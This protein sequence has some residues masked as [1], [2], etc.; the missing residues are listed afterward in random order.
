MRASDDERLARATLMRLAEPGDP[1]L[2]AYV[3]RVGPT[4]AVEAIED[5]SAALKS[6]AAYRARLAP[7]E[8]FVPAGEAAASDLRRSRSAGV[9]LVVPGDLEWP[10][11][12]GDLALPKVDGHPA[13]A[14][15]LGLWVRGPDDLRMAVLRSVAVVG[16][17]AATAY[18]TRVASD[19]GAGLAE[20]GYCAVS[21]GAY[22]I[23]ACAHRG[24]L[25]V[26]GMTVC[27]LAS[28][29]DVPYPL[30]HRSMFDRIAADG[31]LVSEQPLGSHPTRSRFLVRNRLIAALTR[32]TVV[33]EAAFRSGA[34][35]T[36]LWARRMDRPVLGV[37]G[38]VTSMLSAGVHREL[39][40]GRATVV[41]SASDVV[42]AVGSLSEALAE[43]GQELARLDLA[44]EE[45][46]RPLDQ[47]DAAAAGVL[48]A[49]PVRRPVDRT[50]IARA[51]G[52]SVDLVHQRL[53]QLRALGLVEEV[54]GGW[55]LAA[56]GS[57]GRPNG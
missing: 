57:P 29:V 1:A 24:S 47:L 23:D 36:T 46:R 15:P 32:G 49:V 3:E 22:G 30:A 18:G 17:R 43:G 51:C 7:H 56:G 35:N 16:S 55:R 53:A 10:S 42:E 40:D 25:A 5:G 14:P 8:G 4:A 11:Q 26:G 39:R 54:P 20:R 50:V 41:T 37:P 34:L 31:I 28:G 33:V 27:V 6:L 52:L 9:R 48:D 19:L 44:R 21:G 45:A 13:S 38:P 12:L 2:H